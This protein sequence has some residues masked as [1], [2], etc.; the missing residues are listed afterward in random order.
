M[1]GLVFFCLFVHLFYLVIWSLDIFM[2]AV[3]FCL[4]RRKIQHGE[5]ALKVFSV[6][7][8]GTEAQRKKAI[9]QGMVQDLGTRERC[10]ALWNALD[11]P[12]AIP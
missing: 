4:L 12:T 7:S 10:P 2:L 11:G 8:P 3:L 9:A 6:S 1:S 5:K